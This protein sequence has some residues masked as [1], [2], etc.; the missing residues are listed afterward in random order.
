MPLYNR[1]YGNILIIYYI[2]SDDNGIYECSKPDGKIIETFE[3]KV[4]ESENYIPIIPIQETTSAKPVY[5]PY[6][7]DKTYDNNDNDLYIPYSANY[8][9]LNSQIELVCGTSSS[10]EW[11]RLDGDRVCRL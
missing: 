9:K 1:K 11:T 5:P 6:T 7:P 3:V 4:K 2:Q 8:G 10:N